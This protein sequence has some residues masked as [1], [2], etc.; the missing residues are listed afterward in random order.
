MLDDVFDG[1]AAI[2][3]EGVA[4]PPSFVLRGL[5]SGRPDSALDDGFSFMLTYALVC[6]KSIQA[7]S[8]V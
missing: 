2:R 4:P 1:P 8:V 6:L 3:S 7:H 5:Q